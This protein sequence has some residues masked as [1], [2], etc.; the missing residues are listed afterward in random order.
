[1]GELRKKGQFRPNGWSEGKGFCPSGAVVPRELA[2]K[3]SSFMDAFG[4]FGGGEFRQG[5]GVDVHGIQVGGG[6]RGG[7]V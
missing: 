6:S 7:R 5:D 2:A 1:M 4:P 3:A